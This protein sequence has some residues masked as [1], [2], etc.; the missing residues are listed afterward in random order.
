MS[1]IQLLIRLMDFYKSTASLG[2]LPGLCFMH[3]ELDFS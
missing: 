3:T 1:A 2:Q